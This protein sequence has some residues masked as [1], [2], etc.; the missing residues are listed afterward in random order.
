MKNFVLVGGGGY[1]ASKHFEAIKNTGNNLLAAFDIAENVGSVDNFFPYAKFFFKLN[2]FIKFLKKN[3]NKINYLVICAPN[4]LH[5]FYIILGLKLNFNVICEKP[6]V[7]NLNQLN[8]LKILQKKYNR[9]VF[10]ILQLRLNKQLS[11]LKNKILKLNNIK[12]EVEYITYR[13]DWFYKSWKGNPK[14][15]GGLATNIGIHLFDLLIWLFGDVE[16][17]VVKKKTKSCI[18]GEIFFKNK[19]F[20]KWNISLLKKDL[21]RLNCKKNFYRMLLI[22]KMK[23]EF[24]DKFK[25]LHTES[26]KMILKNKGFSIYDVEPS[27]KIVSLI[28]K[29]NL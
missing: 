3:K 10:C 28:N 8:K 2:L 15:S 17:L 29:L 11:A 9:K 20:V 21:V 24:S 7:L 4:Y 1:I 5:Y 27:L 12:S 23:I 22:N 16:N 14:K 13:G 6:L 19:S 18:K 26:Y 25:Q